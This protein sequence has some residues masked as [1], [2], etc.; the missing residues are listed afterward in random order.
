MANE[1][2]ILAHATAG[3]L[4]TI[5]SVWLLVELFHAKDS[6]FMRIKYL[7]VLVNIFIWLSFIIGGWYY[8]FDY[9]TIDKYIIKG[10]T[11]LGFSGSA[12]K[13]AHAFFTESKEHFF[14]LGI[15]I[16]LYLLLLAFRTS[17]VTDKKTRQLMIVLVVIL[18]IGGF[19]LEGWGAIMAMGVRLGMVPV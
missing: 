19:I 7:S 10:S 18:V 1:I 8:V 3:S 9:S 13:F 17:F 6:N 12:W 15:I 2:L 16:A 4:S 14:F 11:D 5:V